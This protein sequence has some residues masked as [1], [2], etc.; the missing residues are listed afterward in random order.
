MRVCGGEISVSLLTLFHK[1][2][3]NKTCRKQSLKN[4]TKIGFQDQLLLNTGQKYCR[5]LLESILQYF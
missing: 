3:Y 1:G 5:M 2:K 4:Q